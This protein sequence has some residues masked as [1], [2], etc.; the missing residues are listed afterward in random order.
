MIGIDDL[1]GPRL[2]Q[3]LLALLTSLL[4]PRRSRPSLKFIE[5]FKPMESSRQI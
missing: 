1:V 2:E 4:R 3:I 5:Q